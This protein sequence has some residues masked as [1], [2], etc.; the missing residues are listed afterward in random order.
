MKLIYIEFQ[1]EMVKSY[2]EHE[3]DRLMRRTTKK[4]YEKYRYGVKLKLPF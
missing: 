1:S 2:S 4:R 3:T